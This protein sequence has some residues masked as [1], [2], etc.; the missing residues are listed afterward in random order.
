MAFVKDGFL[1]FLAEGEAKKTVYIFVRQV[2]LDTAYFRT[3]EQLRQNPPNGD[4]AGSPH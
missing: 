1:V 4:L 3:L 2:K